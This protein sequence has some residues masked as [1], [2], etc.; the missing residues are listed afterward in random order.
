MANTLKAVSFFTG[1]GGLDMGMHRAGFDIRLCVEIE[2]KYCD[3]L[4]L[5]YLNWNVKNDNIMNYDKN[6]IYEEA[7]LSLDEQIDLMFGGSPC[8]S[9]STAGKRQAFGDVRGQAMI[10]YIELIQE[11]KPKAFLLE[12]VKGL[13]SAALKHRK[14]EHRGNE[15]EPLEDEEKPGS[16]LA[17]IMSYFDD[18]N[19]NMKVINA[20][21]YGVSQKRERVIFVGIRKDLN[22]NF[23]FPEPTHNSDGCEGKSKWISFEEISNKLQNKIKEQHYVTYSAERLKYM[24]MIPKGGGNWRDLPIDIAEM[25]M[26]G[27]FKSGGGKVGFFRRVKLNKPA[28]T[29]L[30]SPAQK[31]TNLGHPLEDRP[32]SIEEYLIIQGFPIDYKIAGSITDQYT[33]IGNAVP[34]ELAYKLGKA[35]LETLK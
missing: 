10:K 12:N 25:A 31:A 32:L 4:K 21:D 15:F 8:Q 29:L 22:K 28:P 14:L 24:K 6:R 19:V 35:I 23:E 16:V 33:Q 7:G 11:V 30:T 13:L 26:G 17:Y 1:A 20:A 2:K 3:T 9:F 18:Y 27:A 5:N 34:V